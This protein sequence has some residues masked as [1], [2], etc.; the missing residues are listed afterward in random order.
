[1]IEYLSIK[2]LNEVINTIDVIPLSEKQKLLLAY[3]NLIN[4]ISK[5]KY[6]NN[7]KFVEYLRKFFIIFSKIELDKFEFS[8]II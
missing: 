3:K 2:Q 6:Y 1:M 5:F 4:S 7:Y 8:E